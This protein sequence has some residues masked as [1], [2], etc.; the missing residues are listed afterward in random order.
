MNMIKD[1]EKIVDPEMIADQII[2]VRF[3]AGLSI[4][5]RV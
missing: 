3:S 5:E 1:P 4:S 2:L